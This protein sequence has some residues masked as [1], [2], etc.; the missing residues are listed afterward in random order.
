MADLYSIIYY[1]E[2][3]GVYE[4]LLPFLLVFVIIFAILEK[5]YIFGKEPGGDGP[6]TNINVV[7]AVIIGMLLIAQ[8]DM[9]MFMYSYLSRMSLFIIIGIMFMLVIAMFHGG[10]DTKPFEGFGMTVGVIVAIVALLWSLSSSAYGNVFP[11][12]FYIS[13]STISAL[14][15]IGIVIAV[16]VMVANGGKG[17]DRGVTIKGLRG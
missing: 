14:L 15:I 9:V 16:I 13:E 3:S 4:F 10:K 8:T 17:K 7:V 5:T 11:Y 12:W 1:L 2:S 6:R